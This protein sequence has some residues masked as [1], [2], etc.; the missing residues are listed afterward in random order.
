VPAGATSGTVSVTTPGGTATSAAS[1]IVI[2]A[3]A[4]TRLSP[5]S[6]KR[7]ATVTITGTNLGASRGTGSVKFGAATCSKYLF[8]SNTRIRCRVPAAARFGALKVTL[9][10][11]AGAS[12]TRT[13]RVK[14]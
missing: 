4:L 9:H 14:H 6:A 8:W 1:F 5:S 12:N 2:T 11:A 13:F 3:P 7:G 10:T